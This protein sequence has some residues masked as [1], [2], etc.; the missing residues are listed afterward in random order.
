MKYIMV[1]FLVS[2][3]CWIL[4]LRMPPP[5]VN[6]LNCLVLESKQSLKDIPHGVQYYFVNSK[7]RFLVYFKHYQ[8]MIDTMRA[9]S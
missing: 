3:K 9:L 1:Q 2:P 4:I 6:T 7:R 8:Q 5:Q